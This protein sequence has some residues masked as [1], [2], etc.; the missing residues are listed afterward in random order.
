MATLLEITHDSSTTL[1]DFYNTINNSDGALSI[2]VG[3]ALNGSVNGVEM[4][5]DAGVSNLNRIRQ[6][7]FHTSSLTEFYWRFRLDLGNTTNNNAGF[8]IASI[9]VF[10]LTGTNFI[11]ITI[12]ANAGDSGFTI[13]LLYHKD[14]V[15]F[16]SA[17]TAS[18]PSSGDTFIVIRAISETVDGAN[19]GI[20]QLFIDGS[21]EVSITNA[22]NF[23]VFGDNDYSLSTIFKSADVNVTGTLKYD[24][25]LVIDSVSFFGYDLV[26]GGG[27]P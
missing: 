12:D 10:R 3:S 4:D 13:D 7:N 2:N 17:G 11:G 16:T 18:F 24:E 1:S 23:N 5:F 14:G 25:I 20:I 19:D 27:Q 9:D 15:G 21:Q 6:N 26:L 22:E 8:E